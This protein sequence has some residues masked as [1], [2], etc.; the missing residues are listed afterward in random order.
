LEL[1]QIADLVG[2]LFEEVVVEVQQAE[3][4]EITF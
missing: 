1:A 3:L 2:E 4:G